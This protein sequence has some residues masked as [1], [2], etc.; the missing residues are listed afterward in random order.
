[1]LTKFL[2][3]D[4]EELE[5]Q[6]P[7]KIAYLS[8]KDDEYYFNIFRNHLATLHK[9]ISDNLP[10]APAGEN[11]ETYTKHQLEQ[12]D[13]IILF[14]SA[15]FEADPRYR[16]QEIRAIIKACYEK[17]TRIWPI[18]AKPYYWEASNFKEYR[19]FFDKDR[20]ITSASNA[21]EFLRQIV[22]KIDGEVSQM[23][24]E[25]WAYKGNAF[26]RKNQLE[27]ALTAYDNSLFCL[28]NHPYALLGK[29][30]VLNKKGAFEEAKQYSEKILSYDASIQQKGKDYS[31]FNSDTAHLMRAYCK[32]RVLL[33]LDKIDEAHEAFQKLCQQLVKPTD[34]TQRKLFAE[35]YGGLGD[36]FSKQ[37]D[38]VPG[39]SKMY[40]DQA[41]AIFYRANE[42]NP[43]DPA[44]LYKIGNLYFLLGKRLS[45]D[46]YYE[47]SLKIYQQVIDRYP[48]YVPALV[49]Q[50]DVYY[51]LKRFDEALIAYKTA[52]QHDQHNVCA[53][54][55]KGY[56]LLASDDPKEALF[57]FDKALFLESDNAHCYYGKGQALA[58]LDQYD[59]AIEAY[60]KAY[61]CG[62]DQSIDF[63][64]HY[65]LTLKALGDIESIR[66]QEIQVSDYYTKARSCYE[67]ALRQGGRE[68]EIYYG[69]G[70]TYSASKDWSL[71]LIWYEKATSLDPNMAEAYLEMGKAHFELGD[72]TESFRC[73]AWAQKYCEDAKSV[74]DIADIET[75]YGD[76]YYRIAKRSDS[77]VS[78][79]FFKKARLS[80]DHAI[81]ARKH[82]IAYLGL[83]KTFKML[84]HDNEAIAALDSALELKP[85]L[86]E[87]YAVKADCYYNLGQYSDAYTMYKE[88]TAS[89]FSNISLQKTRGKLL[90]VMKRYSEA[91]EVFDDIIK[92]NDDDVAYA[93]W[94][95][96][97]ALHGQEMDEEALQ[98]LIIARKIDHSMQ[99]NLQ[100]RNTLWDVYWGFERKLYDSPH[101]ASSHQY[102]GD[103]LTIL[104]EQPEEAIDAY[105]K[106]LLY[107]RIS[108]DIYGNRGSSY[109]RIYEYQKAFEDYEEALRINP[110][111]QGIREQRE[112]V[113]A[114][115]IMQTNTVA[116]TRSGFWQKVVTWLKP[117][118]K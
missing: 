2:E 20:A 17:G 94:N 73:F 107:G 117:F 26:H 108:A 49:G 82:A 74:I 16:S 90:L 22:A 11:V 60:T 36:T 53:Y 68:K 89:G 21:D 57:A 38:R 105:T 40:Y 25:E 111:V 84:H 32:A 15:S 112:R 71:A 41:I 97:I 70:E 101:D 69:M 67:L 79:E 44:Y 27:E 54:S 85:Q 106:A 91:V 34:R 61:D 23:L 80:Y 81:H 100:Y 42:L 51:Y 35:V 31:W 103:I 45:S 28:P 4:Q 13:I 109:E 52:L 75:A 116:K 98:S 58:S 102:K 115:T 18:L 59:E 78:N 55:G 3:T 72:D 66:D 65:A 19:T 39:D 99:R 86:S 9:K 5:W 62:I 76:A 8:C 64:I 83:G 93:Y 95:K 63:L 113:I 6:D 77:R 104:E 47:E 1:M 87:C 88:A 24:S 30:R 50:G 48:N 56:T 118:N 12:V 43:A 14:L 7:V 46:N 110:N 33:E 37:G 114:N 29:W 10:G 96:A 92:C